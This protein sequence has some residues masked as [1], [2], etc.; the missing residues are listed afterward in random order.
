MSKVKKLRKY[1]QKLEIE[2]GAA[3]QKA[4]INLT[5]GAATP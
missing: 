4:P 3:P 1:F 5:S 2:G